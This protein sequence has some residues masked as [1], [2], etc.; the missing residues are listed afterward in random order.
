LVCYQIHIRQHWRTVAEIMQHIVGIACEKVF[1]YDRQSNLRLIIGTGIS[2]LGK[3]VFGKRGELCVSMACN[4]TISYQKSERINLDN[5]VKV[6]RPTKQTGK[7]VKVTGT[8]ATP[9]GPTR[10]E[11]IMKA[12][13]PGLAA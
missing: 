6:G 7:I 4:L 12:M 1:E 3:G 13:K 11:R 5:R 9:L 10:K 8:R 2:K